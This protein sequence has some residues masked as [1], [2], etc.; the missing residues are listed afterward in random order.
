MRKKVRIGQ[1]QRK[2]E[3]ARWRQ[4]SSRKHTEENNHS[5][6]ATSAEKEEKENKK[7]QTTQI[8]NDAPEEKGHGEMPQIGNKQEEKTTE[9]TK[10]RTHYWGKVG[11]VEYNPDTNKWECR[12]DEC[13]AEIDTVRKISPHR[14]NTTQNTTSDTKHKR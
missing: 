10:R 7:N 3:E 5:R 8:Q 6:T 2:E 1:K 12:I 13:E 14:K 9:Q 4:T 11:L